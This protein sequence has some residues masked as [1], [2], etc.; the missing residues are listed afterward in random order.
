MGGEEPRR[1][2]VAAAQMAP[3]GRDAV[4][5]LDRAE[6]LVRDAVAA[7]A[8]VV[9]LPELFEGPYFPK[10]Q[11]SEHFERARP[12]D[13]H[14]AVE[15]MQK[16][17]ADLEVVLPVSVFERA[18]QAHF[19]TT[20]IVDADGSV[21][22]AYRKTHIPDGPGYSEKFYF[23]P[24]DGQLRVW[25]TWH[26]DIGVAICWDQWFPEVARVLALRG[27]EL[28]LYPT[29]IGSEPADPGYDSS[30]HWQRVMQGHAAANLVPV[31]ATNRTGHEEGIT[32]SLD[33]Y[34]RSFIADET[35]AIATEA[36]REGEEIVTSTFDLDELRKR[37]AG[38][39]LFRDR[40]PDLYGPL[41][42]L[43]GSSGSSVSA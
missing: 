16:I 22:G 3:G 37:R 42:T 14:P 23:N 1:I 2:T 25:H 41:L 36:A 17:A 13:G 26:A 40:R 18:G 27:A 5:N 30:D 21:L 38:W 20:V 9:L 33:F 32:T 19:N 4:S 11:A 31:V 7:G 15:R 34:G 10:D 6:Q 12:L 39:G 24:G 29:A 28:L 8:Q 35:G 43:D